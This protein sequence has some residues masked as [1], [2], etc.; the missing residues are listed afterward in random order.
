MGESNRTAIADAVSYDILPMEG[1]LLE[2]QWPHL[3]CLQALTLRLL[4][5][6]NLFLINALSFR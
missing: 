4:D 3:T 1:I 5:Y 6:L 2:S